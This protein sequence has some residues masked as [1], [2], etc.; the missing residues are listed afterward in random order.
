MGFPTG[1]RPGGGVFAGR[2]NL[3]ASPQSKGARIFATWSDSRVLQVTLSLDDRPGFACL[4]WGA[5]CSL[6]AA[7][8]S[9]LLTR[10]NAS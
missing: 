9:S 10:Q 1:E 4:V 7:S 5:M 8:L 6:I 3:Q 2:R